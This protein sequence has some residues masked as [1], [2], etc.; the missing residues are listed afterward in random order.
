M[1]QTHLTQ[2]GHLPQA[3]QFV[4]HSSAYVQLFSFWVILLL[5]IYGQCHKKETM[6]RKLS[7]GWMGWYLGGVKYRSPYGANNDFWNIYLTLFWV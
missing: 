5:N 1:A 4:I 6:H 2:L 7:E 3:S